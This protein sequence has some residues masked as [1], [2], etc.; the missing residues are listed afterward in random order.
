MSG[1]R[2]P[3]YY[4]MLAG[5]D[6]APN[7]I[8]KIGSADQTVV[9]AAAATD[10]PIGVSVQSITAASGSRADV[11]VGGVYEIKAGG[12]ISRGDRITSDASGKAVAAAP[13]AGT[14]N[15]IIGFALEAAVSG[16]LVAVLIS[17]Q[18]YQ[19]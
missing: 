10:K 8:V 15:G 12:T 19:G 16:D 13:A 11:V 1:I 7:L 14:N 18:T 3:V 9:K 5:E 2:N 6:I 4:P 17:P